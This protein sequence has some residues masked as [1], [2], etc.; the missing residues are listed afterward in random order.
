MQADDAEMDDEIEKQLEDEAR[1]NIYNDTTLKMEDYVIKIYLNS[2][3]S[4]I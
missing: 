1:N 2:F 3:K 4:N